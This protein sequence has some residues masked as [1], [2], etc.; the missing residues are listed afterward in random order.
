MLVDIL[1]AYSPL[2]Y[3]HIRWQQVIK[4]ALSHWAVFCLEAQYYVLQL[5]QME[6]K[7]YKY[8]INNHLFGSETYSPKCCFF[9]MYLPKTFLPL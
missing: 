8:Y 2:D 3:K 1:V 5:K 7:W 4:Q 6:T 9:C